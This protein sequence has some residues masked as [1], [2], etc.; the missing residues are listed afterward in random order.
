ME[1]HCKCRCHLL[2]NY[3][4]CNCSCDEQISNYSDINNEDDS[5][6][7]DIMSI[8]KFCDTTKTIV[9]PAQVNNYLLI[10]YFLKINFFF[11]ILN[12]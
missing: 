7:I 10:I 12:C 6:K 1:F 5:E 8:I 11:S 2:E 4:N 3:N 9:F